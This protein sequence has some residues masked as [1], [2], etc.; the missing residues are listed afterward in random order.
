MVDNLAALSS[1]NGVLPGGLRIEQAAGLTSL[2]GLEGI[3]SI[4][5]SIVLLDTCLRNAISRKPGMPIVEI[6]APWKQHRTCKVA[7]EDFLRGQRLQ[8][9]RTPDKGTARIFDSEVSGT[10]G[11]KMVGWL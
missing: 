1:L 10:P 11:H 6:F 9:P 7:L 8:R 4:L 2:R 3:S 5:G